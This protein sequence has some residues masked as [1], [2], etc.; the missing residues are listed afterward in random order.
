MARKIDTATEFTTEI[1]RC[2]PWLIEALQHSTSEVTPEQIL[3]R[4]VERDYQLWTTDN[5]AAITS[6]TDWEGKRV[7]C[8]FLIGG[9]K[10]KAMPEILAS[11]NQLEEYARKFA[12]VGLLGIGRA[13][14]A[15]VLP[16]IGFQVVSTDGD[17]GNVYFKD[18][19]DGK[20]A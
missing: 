16:A 4:L 7:C 1:P 18:L 5:A 9:E 14:W 8:L 17:K 11:H 15:K 12:C 20:H 19:I 2:F 3:E 6:I 10:G 13:L